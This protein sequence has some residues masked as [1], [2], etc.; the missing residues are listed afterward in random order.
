MNG[1]ESVQ[2][3]RKSILLGE[4]FRF[5]GNRQKKKTRIVPKECDLN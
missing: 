1:L 3:K 4:V 5:K 2:N